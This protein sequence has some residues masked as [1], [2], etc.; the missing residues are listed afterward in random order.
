MAVENTACAMPLT[1]VG[2][3]GAG[4]AAAAADA[5]GNV[6]ALGRH[7]LPAR[8]GT[9]DAR[10]RHVAVIALAIARRLPIC[11]PSPLVDPH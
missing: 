5:P 6:A 1:N 2:T 7:R 9:H 3:A 8:A 4:A 10:Q 11:I